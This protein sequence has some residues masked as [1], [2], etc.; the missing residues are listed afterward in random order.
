MPKTYTFPTLEKALRKHD[1]RFEFYKKLAKVASELYIILT[2][3]VAPNPIRLNATGK[4]RNPKR[5]SLKDIL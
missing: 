5:F 2:L 1:K 3:M 4:Y